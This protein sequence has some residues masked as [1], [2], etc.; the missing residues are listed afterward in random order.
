[1]VDLRTLIPLDEE[2][3]LASVEKTGRTIVTYEAQTT[4]GF[5]AEVTARPAGGR[6][7]AGCS[8]RSA[9]SRSSIRRNDRW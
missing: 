8:T 9:S 5:G 4:G 3:V 7:Q 6:R 1:M 2:T